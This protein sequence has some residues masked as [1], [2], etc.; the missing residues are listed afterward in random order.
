MFTIVNIFNF[1]RKVS[2]LVGVVSYTR[3]Q[4]LPDY[5]IRDANQS[6]WERNFWL[7]GLDYLAVASA[8]L[9][10]SS[11]SS[12]LLFSDIWCI[13]QDMIL[14][15]YDEKPPLLRLQACNP[16]RISELRKIVTSASLKIS[17]KDAYHGIKSVLPEVSETEVSFN[18]LP[19][20]DVQCST[21]SR[22]GNNSLVQSLYQN[23][24]FHLL[25]K[26]MTGVQTT[27]VGQNVLDVQAECAWRLGEWD[28]VFPEEKAS[29]FNVSVFGCLQSFHNCDKDGVKNWL[30][31]SYSHILDSIT[32]TNLESSA[33]IYS[34]LSKLKLLN[35]TSLFS[36][37]DLEGETL[38]ILDGLLSKDDIYNDDF[39]HLEPVYSVRMSLLNTAL[40]KT[41]PKLLERTL[42][43]LCTRAR[44]SGRFWFCH[45][46]LETT[47]S[48]VSSEFKFEKAKVEW[49]RGKHSQ[50]ILLAKSLLQEIEEKKNLNPDTKQLLP[51]LLVSLG[52]WM[53]LEKTEC[54]KIILNKYF[55][56]AV[57]LLEKEGSRTE[58]S[59][60]EAYL[61]LANLADQH[62]K[63][64]EEYMD[65]AEFKERQANINLRQKEETVLKGALGT[66]DKAFKQSLI[67]KTRFLAIDKLEIDRWMKE[68]E[69]Y[70]MTSME[71]YLSVLL[72]GDIS[73]AVYR[74]IS[75]WFA[76]Q[77]NVELNSLVSKRLPNIPTYR[78]VPLLYQMAAR[79]SD[80]K[81]QDGVEFSAVLF[82]CIQRCA[83]EHPHHVLPIVLALKNANLDEFFE[84]NKPPPDNHCGDARSKAAYIMLRDMK[85]VRNF[86]NIIS[87]YSELSL[88]LV[89]LAYHQV[90]KNPSKSI[91]IPASYRYTKIKQ[92]DDVLVPTDYVPVRP[93]GDYSRYPGIGNHSLL[94]SLVLRFKSC[95]LS[96][97]MGFKSK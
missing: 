81:K 26:Y 15:K 10:C 55:K 59:L 95:S 13:Q 68:K 61:G 6:I 96:P 27:E 90:S 76:N 63:K 69:T 75:L 40:I 16:T 82:N 36:K 31:L 9:F 20:L 33:E 22:D 97:Q 66:I 38:S 88:G 4:V 41:Q 64:A 52:Q 70:L 21:S 56:R 71:Y 51:E 18:N 47:R 29:S 77:D 17:D 3:L 67:I 35:E 39:G 74:M 85:K 79:M 72:H 49:S 19:I 45:S 58:S 84:N 73:V 34:I 1:R 48:L 60:V 54:S 25:S 91:S 93:D 2:A 57:E 94:P 78:L 42:L 46:I 86:E 53:N 5:L 62:Y 92:W 65:S 89:E 50:G 44:E 24:L 11:Y 30:N 43:T 12:A 7:P 23:G 28:N 14:G 32:R 8:A 80:F 37:K 87:K 83:L